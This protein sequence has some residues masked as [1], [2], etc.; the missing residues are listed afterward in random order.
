[1]TPQG[2]SLIQLAQQY[3]SYRR[4]KYSCYAD[5]RGFHTIVP[6]SEEK[7]RELIEKVRRNA[8]SHPMY[9]VIQGNEK[10]VNQIKANMKSKTQ[11]ELETLRLVNFLKKRGVVQA[12]IKESWIV[13]S[14]G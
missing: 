7:E 11:D 5:E 14:E 10:A 13:R 12:E 3:L 2:K 1:M 6:W 4:T 9:I 8:S